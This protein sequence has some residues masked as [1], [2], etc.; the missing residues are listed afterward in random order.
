VVRRAIHRFKYDG[1]FKRGRDLGRR[2]AELVERLMPVDGIDLVAPVP[3]H[4][5]RFRSRGFNQALILADPVAEA[6]SAPVHDVVLRT[7]N[8]PPQVG[9]PA[10]QRR[11]NL[12]NAFAIAP[13]NVE[14]VAGKRILVIDDVMTTGATFC[15]VAEA[16]EV[17]GAT[18]ITGLALAR[19]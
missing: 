14:L 16:M 9:L 12:R 10:E 4:P 8:T 11:S 13:D 3:L 18:S 6:I 5:R 1:E 17:A 15:A 19:D 2:L 7:R